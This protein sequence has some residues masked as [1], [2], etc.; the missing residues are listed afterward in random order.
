MGKTKSA[1]LGLE[2]RYQLCWTYNQ[3]ITCFTALQNLEQDIAARHNREVNAIRADALHSGKPKEIVDTQVAVYNSDE[4]QVIKSLIP[5]D[6]AMVQFEKT[7][8]TLWQQFASIQGGGGVS[9][10]QREELTRK[11]LQSFT[12]IFNSLPDQHFLGEQLRQQ[13]SVNF[14]LPSFEE[15]LDHD[16]TP[17]VLKTISAAS[18]LFGGVGGAAATFLLLAPLVQPHINYEATSSYQPAVMAII[19]GSLIGALISAGAGYK[20]PDVL[21]SIIGHIYDASVHLQENANELLIQTLNRLTPFAERFSSNEFAKERSQLLNSAPFQQ[22][23]PPQLSPEDM[24][25]YIE[26]FESQHSELSAQIHQQLANDNTTA[27]A[28][29]TH[30]IDPSSK[31]QR[32]NGAR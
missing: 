9:D 21:L 19:V 14:P 7:I 1:N 27:D 29:L 8:N 6:E 31:T 30:S 17:Y 24:Q 23:T 11:A 22:L 4:Q 18:A 25:A 3:F 28:H 32:I 16:N 13:Q 20:L 12:A 5:L 10:Q 15:L 26:A 2:A